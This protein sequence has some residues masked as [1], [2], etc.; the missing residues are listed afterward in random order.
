MPSCSIGSWLSR[1][2][3]VSTRCSGRPSMA[4]YSRST[5]RVVPG[6]AVTMAASRS[7]RAFSRLDLPTL[8]APASTTLMPSRSRRPSSARPTRAR[9]SSARRAASVARR[10]S[11]SRSSSSSGKSSPA[12]ICTRSSISRSDSALICRENSPSRLRRA[13][14]AAAVL[15]AS[16]RSAT[17]SACARSSLSFRNARWLNSPGAAW[18][19]PSASTRASSMSMTTGPPWPCNSTT[20][21]PVNE[22]G[23][24]KY[25]HRP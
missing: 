2:P 22:C 4:R 12:S 1:R 20:S 11:A 18:R 19:A 10:P 15:A 23:A 13:A 24:G 14:R 8:G 17:A 6:M 21:C 5:S 7:A 25:R 16:I 3:A 9:S